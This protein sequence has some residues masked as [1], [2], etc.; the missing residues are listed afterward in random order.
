MG[1][2][3][4]GAP[5]LSTGV[6]LDAA[7]IFVRLART[8]ARA[9]ERSRA[10]PILR[11][12]VAAWLRARLLVARADDVLEVLH[13]LQDAGVASWLAGGWGVDALLG[14]QTRAH[15]DVDV[16]VLTGGDIEKRALRALASIG[17]DE[18]VNGAT[19]GRRLPAPVR[20][21]DRY[22]RI[23]DLIP[24][25]L[26]TLPFIDVGDDISGDGAA[27]RLGAIGCINGQSVRCL[28]LGAQL[29]LHE[30]FDLEPQQRR[31]LTALVRGFGFD[32]DRKATVSGA[33]RA[34]TAARR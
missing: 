17:I 19:R 16:I 26:S 3:A 27:G 28:S 5:R 7:W 33:D 2:R 10:A 25:E 21:R 1:E 14:R 30:G 32:S 18:R 11:S 13:A 22:G 23:V 8:A 20:L 34:P 4:G 15:H 24:V 12:R 29:A 31:D 6:R 9:L